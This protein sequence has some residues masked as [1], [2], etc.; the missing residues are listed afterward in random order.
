MVQSIS[1]GKSVRQVKQQGR[2]SLLVRKPGANLFNQKIERAD[3]IHSAGSDELRQSFG[4]ALAGA[5]L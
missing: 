4:K 3:T 1:L 2:N 5:G